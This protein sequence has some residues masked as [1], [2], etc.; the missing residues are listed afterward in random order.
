[1][2][3]TDAVA[4]KLPLSQRLNIRMIVFSAV[5]LLLVGHPV[6]LYVES[7]VT[8][9]IK[10]VGG[11]YK[12]VDLKAMSSFSFDQVNGTLNDVP[13]KWRD[14]NGQK[15]VVFGEIWA[16]DAA[17]P[18][19]PNF[20]LVY[21]IQKCCFSG[22]PQIQHF[23]QSRVTKGA[24]PYLSGLVKVR[25]ILHVDVKPGEGKIA[26]VYQLDVESVEPV[27]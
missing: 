11:G 22:P 27:M 2:T 5:V 25:G 18:D 14:L 17:G 16:P 23:V 8:G 26:S 3:M 4:N 21:S 6:Y 19:I 13:Q 24:V 15:V 7:E 12:E 9:G 20:E 1:M 10:N